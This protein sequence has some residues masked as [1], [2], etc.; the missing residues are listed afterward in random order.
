MECECAPYLE[1]SPSWRQ[2]GDRI[3]NHKVAAILEEV[4]QKG[5]NI[6]KV[7][8]NETD[9]FILNID[10]DYFPADREAM[11]YHRHVVTGDNLDEEIKKT[12][13]RMEW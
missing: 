13:T 1:W 8:E 4:K 6:L 3:S 9:F 7:L 2:E 11:V 10:F 5:D 12:I